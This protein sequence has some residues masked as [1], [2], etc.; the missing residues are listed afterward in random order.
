MQSQTMTILTVDDVAAMR[1]IL[2]TILR[3]LGYLNVIEADDG[4]VALS[5]LQ[6]EK[7]DLVISDCHMPQMNGVELIRVM[8]ANE[9][10]KHIPMVMITADPGGGSYEE[11]IEAGVDGYLTKPFTWGM[12]QEKIAT[13][14]EL[15]DSV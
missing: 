9:A 5:I 4:T 8:R 11:A 1:R 3:Q 12:L 6:R 7:V 13:A 2:R 10:W 14:L 15:R